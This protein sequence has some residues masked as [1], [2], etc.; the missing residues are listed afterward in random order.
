MSFFDFSFW[1]SFLSNALA[2]FLGVI[3]GIPVA[4]WIG[5]YQERKMELE[6]KEK[7][8]KLIHE[9]LSVN[10][11]FLSEWLAEPSTTILDILF[12]HLRYEM[13]RAF[14][15]GGEIQWIKDAETLAYIAEAF[16]CVRTVKELAFNYYTIFSST[17]LKENSIS[18]KR[19][20]KNL[21]YSAEL[22]I[23][24]VGD[25][26]RAVYKD[27]IPIRTINLSGGIEL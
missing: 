9:E 8:L 24:M 23:D 17:R 4:L 5:R 13:W 2:T 19:L 20:Y 25:A 3:V 1:Q 12:I 7:I 10:H 11:D 6:K 22:A 18:N 26:L 21:V 15:D 27:D 14:S 16:A